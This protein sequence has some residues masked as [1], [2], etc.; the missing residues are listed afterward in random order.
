M[1]LEVDAGC[2]FSHAFWDSV[3]A[4]VDRDLDGASG[5]VRVTASEVIL[6]RPPRVVKGSGYVDPSRPGRA[7]RRAVKK[8]RVRD[9]PVHSFTAPAVLAAS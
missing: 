1:Q 9:T 5:D 7:E 8:R 6:T 4:P 3:K 2:G